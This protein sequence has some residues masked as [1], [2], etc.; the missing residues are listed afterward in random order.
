MAGHNHFY[1]RCAVPVSGTHIIQHITHGAGGAPFYSMSMSQP[2]MVAGIANTNVIG[3]VEING[4]TLTHTAY[5]AS[6]GAVVDTV[7][8][9]RTTW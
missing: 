2:Y 3:K 8:I 7:S 1:T 6:T 4:T 9:D 5:N